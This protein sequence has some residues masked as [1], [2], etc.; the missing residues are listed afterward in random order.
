MTGKT[1]FATAAVGATLVAGAVG[2][3][4]LPVAGAASAPTDAVTAATAPTDGSLVAHR[5]RPVRRA[6]LRDAGRTAAEAIGVEP[7]ALRDALR[8]GQSIAEVAQANGV[9]PQAV[10]DAVVQELSGRIDEAVADG[11]I[12]E[13]RADEAKERLPERVAE[14]VEWHRGDHRDATDG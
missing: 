11:R 1:L 3:V 2:V 12:T 10:V 13:E 4:T 14:L 8:D 6:V 7:S 5:H 9:E